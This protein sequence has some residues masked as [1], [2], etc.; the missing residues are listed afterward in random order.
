MGDCLRQEIEDIS[1]IKARAQSAARALELKA[2]IPANLS[3]QQSAQ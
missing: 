2:E 1:L 3:N